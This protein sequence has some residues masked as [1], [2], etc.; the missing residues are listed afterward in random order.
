MASKKRIMTFMLIALVSLFFVG[1]SDDSDP[2]TTP[3][4]ATVDT[5]PPAP[6]SNL[7]GTLLTA[8]RTVDLSW[9][10]NTV[11]SDLAGYI[12]TRDNGDRN[13]YLVDDPIN[14]NEYQDAYPQPGVNIYNVYSVDDSGNESAINS[15]TIDLAAPRVIND[16][17]DS[18]Q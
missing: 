15:V 14:V 2:V 12:I 9:D 18:T 3:T 11:D 1:C 7:T 4:A 13:T 17:V 8:S 10:L 6:P 16:P 5:A